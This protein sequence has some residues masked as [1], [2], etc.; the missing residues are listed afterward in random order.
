MRGYIGCESGCCES[1]EIEQGQLRIATSAFGT[2]YISLLFNFLRPT[3]RVNIHSYCE[4][5]VKELKMI[6]IRHL[7]VKGMEHEE[8]KMWK[9]KKLLVWVSSAQY[10]QMKKYFRRNGKTCLV[11]PP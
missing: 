10:K 4:Y 5:C 7:E 8:E 6:Q 9:R 11:F 3:K 2:S 1:K